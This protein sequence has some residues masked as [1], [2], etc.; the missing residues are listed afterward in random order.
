[1]S[2]VDYKGRGDHYLPIQ[3][4]QWTLGTGIGWTV[5]VSLDAT[6]ESPGSIGQSA[7]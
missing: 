3:G 2:A 1:M 4:Q 7:R 6:E 5:A